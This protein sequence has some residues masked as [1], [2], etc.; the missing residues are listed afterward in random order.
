MSAD[1]TARVSSVPT[2][3]SSPLD[4]ED[5][6]KPF[7]AGKVLGAQLRYLRRSKG[8][9]IKDV[10]PQI[11][12]SV[13]KISRMERGESPPREQD[14]LD[15]VR[16]YGVEA[17][18]Q[19]EEILELIQRAK[20]RSWLHQYSD[21]T[22]GWLRRLI[23]LED[24]ATEI[25]T[26]ETQLVP[27]LLQV[28]DYTRA[29]I[30]A[31]RPDA[32]EEEM[33]RRVELRRLRQQ[34]LDREGRP[35]LVA[36]LDEAILRRPTGGPRVMCQQLR[37]LRRAATLDRI[38]IRIVTFEKGAS[39]GPG[40]P[41][42]HLAFAA[43][44]PSEIIYLEQLNSALYLSKRADVESYRLVLDELAYAA[45]SRRTSLKLL[46]DAIKKY[47]SADTF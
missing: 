10:A 19:I 45:E 41:V 2:A 20:A 34:L 1:L 17:P 35:Q 8:L 40:V 4:E 18:E 30:K 21:I 11:R 7:V 37:Y 29:V 5:D 32:T 3:E 39:I 16:H 42:T 33:R 31:A 13:S 38:N 6:Y 26:Y 27:G 24:S 43:N 44:G 23:G 9:A 47:A 12:A 28:P 15:L 14:V 22:P 46:D 36:L 25:R